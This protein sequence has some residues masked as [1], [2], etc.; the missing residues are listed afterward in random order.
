MELFIVLS[1]LLALGSAELQDV[2]GFQTASHANDLQSLATEVEAADLP[3]LLRLNNIPNGYQDSA[4]QVLYEDGMRIEIN[5]TVSK[6]SSEGEEGTLVAQI[7]I[8]VTPGAEARSVQGDSAELSSDIKSRVRRQLIEYVTRV[9]SNANC[10]PG[11]RRRPQNPAYNPLPASPLTAPSRPELSYIGDT[12]VNYLGDQPQENPDAE[13]FDANLLRKEEERFYASRPKP[14]SVSYQPVRSQPIRSHAQPIRSQPI[15][16][17]GAVYSQPIR[18]QGAVYSQ[19]IRSQPL[20]SHGAVY[21]QPIRSQPIRSQGAVYSQPIRSQP[22]RSQGAVYS[23]PIRSQPLRSQPLR[24]QPIQSQPIRSL[25]LM[26][27]PAQP[28]P[29]RTQSY[30]VPLL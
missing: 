21:S 23:Q 18:S 11:A 9:G 20:R 19:P 24:T 28:Q 12:D 3:E 14:A 10:H 13:V 22:I 30:T 27:G 16:S 26:S 15:R 1:V 29:T 25:P 8:K 6:G 5:E 7:L 17:H 4:H 2:T